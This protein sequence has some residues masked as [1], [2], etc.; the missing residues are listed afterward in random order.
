[1]KH[2]TLGIILIV[3][4]GG[5]AIFYNQSVSKNANGDNAT[6]VETTK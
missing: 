5:M 4:L 3:F 6:K 1:M 2:K